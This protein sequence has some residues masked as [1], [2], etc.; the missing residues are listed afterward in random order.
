MINE[1]KIT[2]FS[3]FP[4]SIY[5]YENIFTNEILD[6]YIKLCRDI[7]DKTES[8]GKNWLSSVYNTLGTYNLIEDK[9]FDFMIETITSHLKK[10]NTMMASDYNYTCTDAWVNSYKKGDYQ[11]WHNHAGSTYSAVLFLKYPEGS[12]LIHFQ[13]PSEPYNMLPIRN[14]KEYN[15]LNIQDMNIN[16]A[17][18]SLILFRS[19]LKHM[20]PVNNTDER[21]TIAFNF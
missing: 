19:Y 21:I 20:V 16:P 4:T 9:R 1:N 10:F 17:E 15:S 14:I 2:L 3:A 13:S 6:Y 7:Q 12:S 18:N 8:G 5:Y 11:E